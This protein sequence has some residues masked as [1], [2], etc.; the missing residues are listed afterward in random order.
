MTFEIEKNEVIPATIP[1]LGRRERYPWT[2]MEVG[3]SFF[4]PDGD[5]RKVAGAA[6]HAARRLGKR[7]I[8][9]SVEGGVRIWRSE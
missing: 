3:D 8:V 4:I 9:R 1:N 5:K 6:S 2:Q 7:F